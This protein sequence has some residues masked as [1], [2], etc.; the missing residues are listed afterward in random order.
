MMVFSMLLS[1]AEGKLDLVR[2][3]NGSVIRGRI[4]EFVVDQHVKVQLSD[5][6]YMVCRYDEVDRISKSGKIR[7]EKDDDGGEIK[8]GGRGFF[9]GSIVHGHQT[10]I[11]TTLAY[12]MQLN[13]FFIG[14]GLGLTATEENKGEGDHF[15]MPVFVN[16]R[17]DVLKH[18]STPYFELRAGSEIAIEGETGFYGSVAFGC[19]IHR[20][21]LSMGL[22]QTR[23]CEEEYTYAYGEHI[24]EY[25]PYNARNLVMSVG[26]EF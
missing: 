14:G 12:G 16:A 13:Q 5:S 4:V 6:S 2:L 23:G 7:P 22:E 20:F 8:N 18:K 26:F 9:N 25:I 11:K 15:A 19:K 21:Q 17:F 1:F 10:G 24:T 3:K